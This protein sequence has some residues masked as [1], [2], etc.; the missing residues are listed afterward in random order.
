MVI[1][2][3]IHGK[4]YGD[5]Q[6]LYEFKQGVIFTTKDGIVSVDTV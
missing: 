2:G 3:V 5:R 4:Y 6:K 1:Q